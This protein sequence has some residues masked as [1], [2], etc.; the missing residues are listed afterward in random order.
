MLNELIADRKG[1]NSY[2]ENNVCLH[3][4][5]R[6]S[7]INCQYVSTGT[8]SINTQPALLPSDIS[9]QQYY[10]T[11]LEK[12]REAQRKINIYSNGGFNLI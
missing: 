3:L 9:I 6:Y 11:I 4:E 2:V 7:F 12:A 5:S 8:L 1:I 10:R